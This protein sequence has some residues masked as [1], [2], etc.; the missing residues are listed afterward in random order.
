MASTF[1]NRFAIDAH[2][3]GRQLGGNEVYVRN[4]LRWFALL[5]GSSEFIA[6]VS[7]PQASEAL[8]ERIRCREVA[9]NPLAR[10]GYDLTRKLSRHRP[11]LLHVQYT[12][13]LVYPVPVVVSVHDVSYL[14]H[15]G[16]FS[17]ARARQLRITVRRT[18]HKA[19][20]V[21]TPSEFSKKAIVRSYGVAEHRVEVIPNGVSSEFHPRSR[22]HTAAGGVHGSPYASG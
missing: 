10:L 1:S 16:Y 13:P 14:E 3:I 22:E 2:T 9:A 12:A 11:S 5:D 17:A 7:E 18:I 8:P 4:L 6:Y 15:P 19:A 20:T 21:L